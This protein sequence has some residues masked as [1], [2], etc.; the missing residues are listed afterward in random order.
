M[1]QTAMAAMMFK[2]E[3]D[4]S[5]RKY[6]LSIQIHC[7]RI[8]GF[9]FASS[10]FD[11]EFLRLEWSSLL[12]LVNEL[13]ILLDAVNGGRRQTSIDSE[14][15]ENFTD[16]GSQRHEERKIYSISR[17]FVISEENRHVKSFE[18]CYRTS[19]DIFT[20]IATKRIWIVC[21]GHN[22]V[23]MMMSSWW[24]SQISLT[25]ESSNFPW[26]FF[27]SSNSQ[28]SANFH[29]RIALAITI[30]PLYLREEPNRPSEM[31]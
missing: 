30:L 29:F 21:Y 9:P 17:T 7:K 19:I 10:N 3:R 13:E 24:R 23:Q 16:W 18:S 26:N 15:E 5:W 1:I 22:H 8:S 25:N 31:R 12:I 20:L 6:I 11:G 4:G 14:E 2:D 28:N 27:S